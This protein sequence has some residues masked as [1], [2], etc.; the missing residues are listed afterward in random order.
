MRH[1]RLVIIALAT[2]CVLALAAFGLVNRPPQIIPGDDDIIIKG[3]SLDV[4]CG[5]NHGKDCFGGN[6]NQNKPKHKNSS[7]KIVRIVVQKSNGDVLGLFTKKN[8]FPDGKPAVIIT[9][10]DPTPEDN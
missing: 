5:R 1:L 9:Y 4:D 8:H 2:I 6:E 10:R 7:A 3:G